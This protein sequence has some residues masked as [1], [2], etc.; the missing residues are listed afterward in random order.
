MSWRSGTK[1]LFLR[2]SV[3]DLKKKCIFILRGNFGSKQVGR[4]LKQFSKFSDEK[5][6]KFFFHFLPYKMCKLGV[7]GR[8]P[9]E[10]AGMKIRKIILSYCAQ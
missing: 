1:L 4:T 2:H 6:R 7:A 3:S 9:R 8:R 5:W 10:L